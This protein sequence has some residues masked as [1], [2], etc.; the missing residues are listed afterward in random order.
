MKTTNLFSSSPLAKFQ[1]TEILL[2][3]EDKEGIH[4]HCHAILLKGGHND[5]YLLCALPCVQGLGRIY[6]LKRQ[7]PRNPLEVSLSEELAHILVK[8]KDLGHYYHATF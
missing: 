2:Q 5:C 3:S 6:Y 4:H 7:E 1:I 8:G